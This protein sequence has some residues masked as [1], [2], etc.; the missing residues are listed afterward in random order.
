MSK[1]AKKNASERRRAAKRARKTANYLRHG[2]KAGHTGRRQKKSIRKSF[3]G[4]NN[5]RGP[6]DPTPPGPSAKRRYRRL[7]RR[8]NPGQHHAKFPLRPLRKRRHLSSGQSMGSW[9]G[10][11]INS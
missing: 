3:K 4:M 5:P 8:S 9:Q 11:Q 6:Q 1:V 7:L 2:P 10:E